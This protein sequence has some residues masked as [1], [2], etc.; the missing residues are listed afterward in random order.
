MNYMRV[1]INGE[2]WGLY[3]N[4]QQFNK[5]FTRD[6]FNST[7]GARWKVPGSPGGRAGFNYLGDNVA[8]YKRLYQITSKDDPKAWA[9][10]I[11]VF[12]V[13][14]ETPPDKLEAALARC[15]TSTER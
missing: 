4:A 5:D 13:L 12:K 14:N 7:K 6:F 15:S 11:N 9:D 8:D 10:L 1:V 2:S 3:L